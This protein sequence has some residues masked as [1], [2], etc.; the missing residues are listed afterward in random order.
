MAL[1]QHAAPVRNPYSALPNWLYPTFVVGALSLFGIFA[2]WVV[3]FQP[4]LNVVKDGGADKVAG[5]IIDGLPLTG[6][7]RPKRSRLGAGSIESV[8][9]AANPITMVPRRRNCL[10]CATLARN[11]RAHWRARGGNTARG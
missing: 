3:F 6:R 8:W 7:P 1:A 11:C 2:A 5:G 10:H 9:S 4:A